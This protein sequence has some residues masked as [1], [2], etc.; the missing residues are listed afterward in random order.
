MVAPSDTQRDG[1]HVVDF[2]IQKLLSLGW[3]KY[4]AVVRDR[5][6]DTNHAVVRHIATSYEGECFGGD[7]LV[8]GVH[9][10]N[11]TRRSYVLEE[12]LLHQ[13]TKRPVASSTVV[14]ASVDPATG[15]AAPIPD[16]LWRA[17]QEFE[18]REL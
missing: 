1:A 10:L 15:K 13:A 17:I 12:V 11:R 9:A 2:E 16:E 6:G 8:R 4:V 3:Q 18:G 5:A 7:K 14:I